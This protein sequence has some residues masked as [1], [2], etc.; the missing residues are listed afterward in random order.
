MTTNDDNVW[1]L[2]ATTGKVQWRFQPP[3]V[4]VFKNFGIVANRGVA[5]CD[6]K[7][8]LTTLDMTIDAARRRATAT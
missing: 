3:N 2:N 7:L 6:G 5:Y 4:A 8:F 1:A